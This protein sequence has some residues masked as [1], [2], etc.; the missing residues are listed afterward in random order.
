MAFMVLMDIGLIV[1]FI[2]AILPD[3]SLDS[4]GDVALMVINLIAI[5]LIALGTIYMTRHS[6]FYARLN[7]GRRSELFPLDSATMLRCVERFLEGSGHRFTRA[8]ASG[9]LPDAHIWE[10]MRLI[11]EV[12]RL[13]DVGVDITLYKTVHIR[14]HPHCAVLMG[15]WDEEVIRPLVWALDLWLTGA[16]PYRDLADAG[17]RRAAVGPG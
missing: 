17:A 13:G 12:L 16:V 6:L 4:A 10:R 3:S 5:V 1:I 9:P 14:G 2:F 11:H 15:P 7:E 8:G